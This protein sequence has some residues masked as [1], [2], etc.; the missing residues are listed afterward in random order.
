MLASLD[1][2]AEREGE[3]WDP[4]DTKRPGPGGLVVPEEPRAQSLCRCITEKPSTL[5]ASSAGAKLKQ[6]K[7]HDH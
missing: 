3:S 6:N 5:L 7:A 2:L 4:L 1:R